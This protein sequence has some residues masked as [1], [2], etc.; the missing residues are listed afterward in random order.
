M[1]FGIWSLEFGIWSF[2]RLVV[3][4]SGAGFEESVEVREV[5]AVG[6]E[7]E[8]VDPLLL[9]KL[10]DAFVV[11]TGELAEAHTEV[12]VVGIDGRLPAGFGVGEGDGADL[13]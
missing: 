12:A 9:E 8:V 4:A 13:G 7:F 2:P 6:A 11:P 5:V 10:G 1:V 3:P